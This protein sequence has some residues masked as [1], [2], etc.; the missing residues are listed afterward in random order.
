MLAMAVLGTLALAGA[1]EAYGPVP[2]DR[3]LAWHRLE[4]YAFV[5]FTTNTFTGKEWGYG[6]ESPEVFNPTDFDADQV[7]G[8][9]AEAGLKGLILTAKHHD[10]FCLWPSAFT[11][12]S[13]EQSPWREGKGDM[14]R[15]FAE[16]CARRGVKFGIYLSPWDRNHP[17]YGRPA[18]VEYYRNQLTELLSN[19]GPIFEVWFDG[20]NGG[21]GYYGGAREARTIDRLT[22]YEWPKIHDLV[23]SLQPD[24]VIFSDVG[25]DVRWVG[26]EQGYA[27]DPC[28]S[29]LNTEGWAPGLADQE[30]LLA[31]HRN[32]KHW[33]PAETNFS[34]RPGWFYHAEEDDKVRSGARLVTHWFESVGRGTTFHLNIPPDRRGRVHENDIASLR[35]FRRLMDATFGTDLAQGASAKASHVRGASFEASNLLDGDP[36]TYWSTPDEVRTPEVVLEFAGPTRMNVVRFR[37]H[38]PLG[39]RIDAWAVDIWTDGGWKEYAAGESIGACRLV[40]GEPVTTERIRL[41]IVS[42]PVCPALTELAVFVEPD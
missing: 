3:Q 18:Y 26:T 27:G 30:Q 29:T 36:E 19:Y 40:R 24:A 2:S 9:V 33:L 6:D 4:S 42:A 23:R 28:W 15:E 39:Q 13:V 20:A 32:G 1:P 10:G 12:H 38:L 34:I 8:A 41:R 5:H 25:P 11:D 31:G 21:D 37:E 14:V 17:E 35:E 16:A 22:Y 7:V